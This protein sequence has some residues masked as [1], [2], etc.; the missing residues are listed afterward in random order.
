MK[1]TYKAV[2]LFLPRLALVLALL[3]QQGAA[4]AN[5]EGDKMK[6]GHGS[7]KQ[8]L[9]VECQGATAL[10]SPHCGRTP[11][12]AI[13]KQGKA[14]AVFSQHGHIY[15]ATSTDQGKTYS[16]PIAVNQRAEAIYDDGENRPKIVL[17][18][19]NQ[20][21]VSWTHKTPGRYSGNVRFARSTD[22]GNSF[23]APITINKDKAVISHRFDSMAL[24]GKGR[25]YLFWIDKRDK[26]AAELTKQTYLGASIYYAY[27]DDQG[28]SFQSDF[29]W[30][31]NSC[32]CCRIAIAADDQGEVAILWRHVYPGSIR[33]HAIAYISAEQTSITG[34]P[35]IAASDDWKIEGCPHHGP[36]LSFDGNNRAHMAWFT[37]G[38][39]HKGLMYGQYD[40]ATQ[41]TVLM[42]S[43]DSRPAASRPQVQVIGKQVFLLWKRFNGESMDLML[44]RSDDLAQ[45]WQA[46]ELIASTF[47][48]S[49]HPDFLRN[50]DQLFATWHTQADGLLWFRVR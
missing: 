35:P 4:A 30:V 8:S 23:S 42:T 10:P 44:R 21:Y 36:D 22:G 1:N 39:K 33:D 31:D 43:I 47:H 49:D 29:K 38:E 48:G 9:L 17:G 15:L 50:G 18:D 6:Q 32:E 5:A 26:Q 12:Q 41:E 45:S 7:V 13:D 14:Y 3:H 28:A 34:L 19:N 16:A 24:D 46:E 2:I 25:L 20:V 40:F 11:S 37:Q 27:S